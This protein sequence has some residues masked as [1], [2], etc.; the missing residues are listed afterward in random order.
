VRASVR[1]QSC[2][3]RALS[4]SME[5]A[6]MEKL[7]ARVIPGYDL[8]ERSG[9][10]PNIPI[11]QVD[12]ARQITDDVVR[13]G[14]L[15]HFTEL[16]IEVDRDGL[17]GR[18]VSIRLLPQ[19]IKE[20]E[21]LGYSFKKEYGLFVESDPARKTRGWGTLRE[22]ATY[23]LS[24]VGVDIVGNTQLVRKHSRQRVL[25]AYAEVRQIFASI[26]DRREGRV[27]N[28]EGDGGVA[29]FYLGNKNVQATLAG[30]EALLELFTY[31]LFTPPFPEPLRLRVA[32]HAGPCQYFER[33]EDLRSDTLRRLELIESRHTE[34]DTLVISS[35][36]YSDLGNKLSQFFRPQRITRH[37]SLYRYRLEWE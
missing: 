35:R 6:V 17:M 20:L 4:Q 10:P 33:H 15:K 16:L 21:V 11:P 14:Y 9:F 22:A 24:F 3:I 31:N 27:W 25:K 5:V 12:A 34:P 2:L 1:L 13:E 7:A 19:V 8:Y 32:V 18:S 36:V 29:A 23:D 30:M 37:Q 26:V 28:W